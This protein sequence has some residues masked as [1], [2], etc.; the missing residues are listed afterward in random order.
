MVLVAVQYVQHQLTPFNCKCRLNKEIKDNFK[1]IGQNTN[2]KI[3]PAI[4]IGNPLFGIIDYRDSSF[5]QIIVRKKGKDVL[6]R[7]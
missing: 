4:P 2:P 7:I 3:L 6:R 1:H 5:S